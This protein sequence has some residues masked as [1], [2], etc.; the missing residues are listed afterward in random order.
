M[1]QGGQRQG[2][3]GVTRHRGVLLAGLAVGLLFAG[4]LVYAL[5]AAGGSPDAVPG[6]DPIASL[7]AIPAGYL[8]GTTGG[9]AA[10]PDGKAWSAAHLPAEL[11][12]VASNGSTGYI[13]AGGQLHST[14]DLHTFPVLASDVPGTA[15]AVSPDGTVAVLSGRHIATVSPGGTVG[16]LALGPSF[17]SGLLALAFSPASPTTL[18][19][20][21]PVAGLWRSQ[22]AGATWQRLDRIPV[23][24]LLVDAGD[25]QQI[26]VGTQGGVFVSPDAGARWAPT[27]L[28]N[29][30]NGLSQVGGRIIAVGSDRIL[31]SSPTGLSGWAPVAG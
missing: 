29:D 17:P 4:A 5:L 10:S 3:A 30:V 7:A 9:L 25:P 23:Q 2:L 26:F 31:Y 6:T 13:L 14:T 20:G 11:V 22:D 19:G 8:V 27:P 1:G 18:Y 15:I 28:R 16:A 24:A 21:G 12:A